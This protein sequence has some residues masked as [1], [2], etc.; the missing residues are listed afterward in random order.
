[1]QGRGQDRVQFQTSTRQDF[2]TQCLL[3]FVKKKMVFY[4][5]NGERGP[6]RQSVLMWRRDA[7]RRRRH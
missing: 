2:V 3:P 1:M 4:G 7:P 5:L 6:E